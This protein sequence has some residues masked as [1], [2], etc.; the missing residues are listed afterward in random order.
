VGKDK[1]VLQNKKSDLK[2]LVMLMNS[3]NKRY[4]PPIDP[5]LNTLDYVLAGGELDLLLRLG[6]AVYAHEVALGASGM[7]AGSFSPMFE[8]LKEKGFIG[9]S[10]NET[11]EERYSLRPI[12]VGWFEAQASYLIGKPEEKEF[13]R[14]FMEFFTFIQKRN[15]FPFRQLMNMKAR[16]APISNQSVGFVD[17]YKNEKGKS[18]INVHRS[19][20]V[21]DSKVY[22]THSINDLI[23]EYGSTS[24]I[25]QFTCMCRR[26][27]SNMDDPC[28][29]DM[30]DDCGCMGFGDSIKPYIKYGQAR[31]ISKEQAFAVLQK[32]R[33]NGAIHSVFHEL[34]DTNRP[35][36]GICNCCWDCCGLLRSYN[37]GASP[38]RYSSYFIAEIADSAKCTGCKKCEK[39]CPTA[40]ISVKTKEAV[41]DSRKCI[42]CGQC[43]HQ[44]TS[45]AVT[46]VENCRTVFLPM[47]KKSEA[48][49]Q[50]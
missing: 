33:D 46:L 16:K 48:R 8:T 3:Q 39:Y 37:M 18:I 1:V 5:I 49:I 29:V 30:P 44:C 41:I 50:L 19:I 47:L 42:G 40:A 12:L 32:A 9:T 10:Y 38:L 31:Q 25:G 6:T 15:F 23:Q 43:V 34:D 21:P 13:T 35:Q 14:R 17:E 27:K 11:G 45:A 26:M 2:Q 22:P 24:V 36:V 28:R 4:M 7:S 20:D